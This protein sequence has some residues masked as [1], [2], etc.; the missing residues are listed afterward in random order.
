[1]SL[2]NEYR[3]QSE[4]RSWSTVLDAL[5]SLRG[6]TVLDLGCGVGDQA[7]ELVARGARVIGVDLNEE[8]LRVA[9]AKELPRSEFRLADLRAIPELGCR[10]D[11]LWCSFV[12]AYFPDL[13]AALSA[14]AG[15]L[16]PGGWIALTEVDD[17]FG[18]EPLSARTKASF[19][20]YVRDALADGRYDFHM[21]RKLRTHLEQA[22]FAVAQAFTLPDQELSFDGPARPEVV[23]AWGARLDRMRLLR[24]FCGSDFEP[25]REEFLGCLLRAD[26]RS[27][28]KVHGCIATKPAEA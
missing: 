21:G 5:P 23:E 9:Q 8:L 7:A 12:A 1:M 19:E 10:V 6:C 13:P 17:L 11:G 28:A 22:R 15:H 2:A 3:R 27:L 26:H 18:H 20:G 24:D 16:K 25:V 4:W 14:W